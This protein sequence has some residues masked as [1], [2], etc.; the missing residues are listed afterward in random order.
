M[1]PTR[2]RR[3]LRLKATLFALAIA[4]TATQVGG[5][6]AAPGAAG[7]QPVAQVSA[8]TVPVPS[9]RELLSWLASLSRGP[10]PSAGWALLVAGLIGVW[11]IGH[12]R[13]SAADRSLDPYRLRRR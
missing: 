5:A 3:S 13:I 8:A 11:A 2:A 12:R 9:E 4:A 7:W 1:K 6:S 10:P